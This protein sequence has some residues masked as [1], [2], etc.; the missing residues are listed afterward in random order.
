MQGVSTDTSSFVPTGSWPATS[1]VGN[2][3]HSTGAPSG[4]RVAVIEDQSWARDVSGTTNGDPMNES[5][6]GSNLLEGERYV[7]R[8]RSMV[9]AYC[10]IQCSRNRR[11]CV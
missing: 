10:Y 2:D 3:A 8:Y 9:V 1:Q 6:R 7:R 11:V 5:S 4:E